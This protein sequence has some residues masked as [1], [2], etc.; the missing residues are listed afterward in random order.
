M[1]S[2][3]I[4]FCGDQLGEWTRS[5][6]CT[7]KCHDGSNCGGNNAI[8][9]S[10]VTLTT[11][12]WNEPKSFSCVYAKSS[13]LELV[14]SSCDELKSYVCKDAENNF[15]FEA[16]NV[17]AFEAMKE[18]NKTSRTLA[19]FTDALK[20][21][22]LKDK[23]KN[24]AW[25]AY[26]NLRWMDGEEKIT[27]SS[28]WSTKAKCS[29][30]DNMNYI[31]YTPNGWDCAKASDEYPTLRRIAID[32]SQETIPELGASN[33]KE[34]TSTIIIAVVCL[35]VGIGLITVVSFLFLRG[36]RKENSHYKRDNNSKDNFEKA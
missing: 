26:T 10:E 33:S 6:L 12:K 7:T 8:F 36:K 21:G 24:D 14:S 19:Y 15:Y 4:C 1:Q 11:W 28:S 18:C 22:D 9:I 13:S 25:L 35:V 29:S 30:L 23:V 16:K 17:T 31:I 32:D 5:E 2:D 20:K 3:N 34:K 27:I